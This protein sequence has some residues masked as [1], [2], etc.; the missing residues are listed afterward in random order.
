MIP[1]DFIR[2]QGQ[3]KRQYNEQGR[4]LASV[5]KL[6][7]MALSGEVC[8]SW[9]SL[10]GTLS[11]LIRRDG[12]AL[13]LMVCDN[14]HCYKNVLEEYTAAVRSQRLVLSP[15]GGE[16]ALTEQG[17]LDCGKLGLFRPEE[18]MLR[19]EQQYEMDFALR[20]LE[21]ENDQA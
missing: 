6:R 9:I 8:G 10:E 7:Q 2:L 15:G 4:F 13:S 14:S 17:L 3:M 5:E 20:S 21:E 12:D 18:D 1:D 16:L 19:E 11:L